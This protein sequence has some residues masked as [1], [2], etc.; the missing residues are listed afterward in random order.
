MEQ[1]S[2]TSSYISSLVKDVQGVGWGNIAPG[3]P[4]F[5]VD[6]QGYLKQPA[7]IRALKSFAEGPKG[8]SQAALDDKY[9][10]VV[11]NLHRSKP[12]PLSWK[13]CPFSN[14]TDCCLMPPFVCHFCLS[15][16]TLKN[17]AP[18]FSVT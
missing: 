7:R 13:D 1:S 9:T 14:C 3:P 4:G 8:R 2:F 18:A 16:S 12:Y 6:S 5:D 11:Q 10:K 17:Q 15:T